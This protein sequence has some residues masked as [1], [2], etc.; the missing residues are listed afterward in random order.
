MDNVAYI[1]LSRQATL[2]KQM[3]V[4]ANNLANQDTAGFK[5]EQL[6]LNTQPGAP[7][8]DDGVKGP[9]QFVIDGGI[10]RDFSEGELTTT[11]R[12]LDVAI[13]GNAFFKVSTP[14]GERYTKDGRF[15]IDPQGKLVTAQGAAVLDELGSEITLDAANG[16]PQISADGIVSQRSSQGP[17]GVRVGKIGVVRFDTLSVLSK[18][19]NN[20]YVN[21]SNSQPQAAP[22]I[23]MRQG[24]LETSNVKPI[25]QITN[26][27]EVQRAYERVT[28]MIQQTNDLSQSSIDRLAKVA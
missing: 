9:A 5:V 24:M 12:S 10:G 25:I 16:E 26:L 15:A 6:L 13:D 22:D 3:D 2:Q 11:G 14:Q 20:L 28:N 4:I 21:S 1:G 27:I 8:K 7:A 18:E 17:G 23:R 19:G